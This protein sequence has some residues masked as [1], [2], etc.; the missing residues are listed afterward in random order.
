MTERLATDVA[1]IGGGTAG[2]AAALAL[3]GRGLGVV[4][5]EKGVCGA[6]ASGVNFGGV[7]QQGRH[8]A[9]LPIARRARAIWDRLPALIGTD[10]EFRATGHLKLAHSDEEMAMLETY[11]RVAEPYGLVLRLLGRNAVRADYP[12]FGDGVVGGSLC[13]ADGHAN[14]RLLAPAF[15]RAAQRAGAELRE[16]ARVTD[17]AWDGRSFTLQADGLVVESRFLINVAGAWAGQVA[18]WF[19]DPAPGAP[20]CP[21]MLV[22]EPIPYFL[23]PSLGVCGGGIYLRQIDSANVIFGGGHGWGDVELQGT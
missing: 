5:L 11:A 8:P 3:R 17:A 19:G 20:L 6:Q 10:A 23:V 7:R 12:W 9:E 22:A 14:P 16:Q 2:C 21:N 1:I 15:A 4:L 13:A 18:S